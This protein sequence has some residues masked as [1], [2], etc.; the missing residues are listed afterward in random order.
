MK[1]VRAQLQYRVCVPVVMLLACVA[2]SSSASAEDLFPDKGLE[3]AVRKE[4]F[5]KRYNDEP[6]TEDDVKNISRVHGKGLKIKSLEGLQHCVAVQEIDLEHNQIA[7]LKPLADLTL[8]QSINLAGNQ[9][10]SIEPLAELKRVQYLEL[11]GNRVKNIRPLAKMSNMRSLYLSGNKIRKIGTLKE[12]TKVWSLYLAEN[13]VQDFKPIGQLKW[14]ESLDVAK[15]GVES[16][17]FLKPLTEIKYLNLSGNKLDDLQ[18]LVDMAEADEKHRF[19][20][21][22]RIYIKDNP[23]K[24]DRLEQQLETLQQLGARIVRE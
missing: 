6:L 21:F 18:P 13:P 14:L 2:C 22:W 4:V 7:D 3:A 11:T 17:E 5:E 24:S 12:L 16:T 1:F 15:C 9:I 23:L 20:P 19:A 8:L 10:E